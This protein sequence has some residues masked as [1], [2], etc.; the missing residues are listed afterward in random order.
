[1]IKSKK[2]NPDQIQT[3]AEDLDQYILIFGQLD[4]EIKKVV[5]DQT[6]TDAVFTL[7]ILPNTFSFL[8]N[9]MINPPKK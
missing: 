2:I 6:Q 7:K 3:D 5:P 4:D 8:D 9:L 1:M